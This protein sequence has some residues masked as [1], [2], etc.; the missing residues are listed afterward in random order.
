ME[1]KHQPATDLA[2]VAAALN[3]AAMV[4]WQ[5]ATPL[6]WERGPW[7]K[8]LGHAVYCNIANGPK[9]IASVSVHG[10]FRDSGSHVSRRRDDGSY[11]G[12]LPKA[13][14]DRDAEYLTHAANAYPK[15]V[16]N[17]AFAVKLLSPLLGST[18]QVEH[19]QALLRELGEE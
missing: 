16:A 3:K 13:D 1:T 17:L 11:V 2:E 6:P 14:C 12:T 4:K 5:P 15:L 7:I 9:R 10:K 8:S 18:A 19:M